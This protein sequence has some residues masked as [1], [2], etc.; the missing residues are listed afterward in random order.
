MQNLPSAEVYNE[1]I[2]YMSWSKL[3]RE[4]VLYCEK[5]ISQGGSIAD[6]CCGTGS[7][8][9]EL[10]VARPDIE[11]TGVDMETDYLDFA[12]RKYTNIKFIAA[13]VLK[14]ESN[15]RY[16]AVLCTAGLHHLPYEQQEAFIKKVSS[17]VI[18]DG[19]AIIG[20]PYIDSF[21]NETQRK[22]ASA[23]LGY[24][25]LV[26]TI[27]NGGTDDAVDA[28]VTVLRNDV[29]RVEYKNSIKAIK[30]LFEKYFK[31]VEM[32]KTWP[33]IESEYGDYYFILK[34]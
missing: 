15:L 25:Y 17:L 27:Q 1:E 18:S 7:L 31:S 30:P 13:D 16:H 28:A 20:D 22:I 32:H 33:K 4:I 26:E 14:W 3:L 9:G 6:L 8:L 21:S 5:N 2:S 19:F 29:L 11:Y 23:K 24:E 10:Q 34:N 12:E